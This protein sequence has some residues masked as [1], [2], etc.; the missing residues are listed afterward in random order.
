S[1][2]D[3]LDE[4]RQDL[5]R[6]MGAARDRGRRAEDEFEEQVNEHPWGSLLAALGVGFILAKVMDRGDRR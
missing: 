5:R 6:A 2:E 1:V 3:E 4:R